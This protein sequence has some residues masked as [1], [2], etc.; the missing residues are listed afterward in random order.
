MR[1]HFTQEHSFQRKKGE[2]P[3]IKV[4]YQQFTLGGSNRTMFR[5]RTPIA[6]ESERTKRQ[7]DIVAGRVRGLYQVEVM[8]R[9]DQEEAALLARSTQHLGLARV[10]E[11]LP[12]LDATR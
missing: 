3:W 12:W 5:V 4:A 6:A 8:Q 11:V 10:T 7:A 1:A 9:L 2:T